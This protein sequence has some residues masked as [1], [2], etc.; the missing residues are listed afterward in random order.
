MTGGGG[1]TSVLL[2]DVLVIATTP[3]AGTGAS[4]AV[5]A[6]PGTLDFLLAVTRAQAARVIAAQAS[7]AS[8]YFTLAST[9]QGS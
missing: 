1:F 3:G 9:K 6:G 2:Q 7:G 8:L 5:T 4:T